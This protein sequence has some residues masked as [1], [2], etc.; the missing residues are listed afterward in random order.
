VGTEQYSPGEIMRQAEPSLAILAEQI[1]PRIGVISVSGG[2]YRV[3][4]HWAGRERSAGLERDCG[5][6]GDV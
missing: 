4:Q 5:D 1:N 2:A 6:A 3:R